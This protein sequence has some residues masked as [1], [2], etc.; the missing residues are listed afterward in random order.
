M[1]AKSMALCTA[2][3]ALCKVMIVLA[4]NACFCCCNRQ[5]EALELQLEK[6][7]VRRQPLGNDRFNRVYWWGLAG[8]AGGRRNLHVRD[9]CLTRS[10]PACD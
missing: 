10:A 1:R 4:F 2:A 9:A 5:Q 8:A 7:L 6:Y 3:I